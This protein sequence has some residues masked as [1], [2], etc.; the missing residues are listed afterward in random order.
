MK[1]RLFLIS[2]LHD[3]K[4]SYLGVIQERGPL[5]EKYYSFGVL[6]VT[7][8]TNSKVITSLKKLNFVLIR[9]NYSY[10]E[11]YRQAISEGLKKGSRIFHCCDFDRILHWASAYPEELKNSLKKA[12]KADYIIIG[13][14]KRAFATHPLSWQLTEKIN[15]ALLSKALGIKVDIGAGSVLLNRKAANIILDKS[16]ETGF[17][18]LAEWPLLIKEAELKVG[19]LA[20]E[21][22]E[23]E[24]PDRFQNEIKKLGYKKWLKNYDSPYEWQKRLKITS[25]TAKVILKFLEEK[26]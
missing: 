1:K 22:Q 25:Q 6:G 12:K 20:V 24:N 23:W 14:T 9:G 18:I 26:S 7:D 10:A 5:L 2:P 4:G 3:P 11:G 19:H 15:N 17:S 8:T 21:G 13:R 16:R